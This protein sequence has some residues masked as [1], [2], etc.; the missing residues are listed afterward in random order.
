LLPILYSCA[1]NQNFFI[2]THWFFM[3]VCGSALRS[4]SSWLT[5][6]RL[7]CCISPCYLAGLLKNLKLFF[8]RISFNKFFLQLI[9][10]EF[11]LFIQFWLSWLMTFGLRKSAGIS[12]PFW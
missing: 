3:K 8:R 6:N 5:A 10:V 12:L 4:Y 1:D 9:L 11:W 7:L 2:K